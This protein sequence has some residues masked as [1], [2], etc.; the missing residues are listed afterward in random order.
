MRCDGIF[1]AEIY[2]R[3]FR[4][5]PSSNVNDRLCHRWTAHFRSISYFYQLLQLKRDRR[6]REIVWKWAFD[7]L[8]IAISIPLW[9]SRTSSR[10]RTRIVLSV[11]HPRISCK[12]A[13]S[14][15]LVVDKSN[16]IVDHERVLH[17][18]CN[19]QSNYWSIGYRVRSSY[20]ENSR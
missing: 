8:N 16:D 19:E 5:L 10:H 6:R 18:F 20:C 9:I 4:V 2:I 13:R 14:R 1:P 17:C 7:L 3:G 15:G 11:L 12:C